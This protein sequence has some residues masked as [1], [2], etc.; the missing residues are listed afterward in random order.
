MLEP[1]GVPGSGYAAS[2]YGAPNDAPL[3]GLEVGYGGGGGFCVCW[4]GVWWPGGGMRSGGG[5]CACEPCELC[6]G[7][8]V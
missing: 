4:D 1:E 7:E 5:V 3:L 2:P 6:G 8:A